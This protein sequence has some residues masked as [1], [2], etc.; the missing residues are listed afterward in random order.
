MTKREINHTQA[1]LAHLHEQ[2]YEP[3]SEIQIHAALFAS[4]LV[5]HPKPSVAELAAVLRH[6]DAEKWVAGFP[7]R[8]QNQMRWTLTDAGEAARLALL[9]E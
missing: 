7:G 3:V 8:F 1:V 6:A 5:P 9:N 4:P 2:D